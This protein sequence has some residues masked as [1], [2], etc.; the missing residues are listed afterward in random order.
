MP[1]PA[2]GGVEGAGERRFLGFSAFA[3]RSACFPGRRNLAV[4]AKPCAA[5]YQV[6]ERFLSHAGRAAWSA[7]IA[8]LVEHVIRNDGVGGS[9]P[10]CGT[11]FL[12]PARYDKGPPRLPASR[13]FEVDQRQGHR[14]PDQA[15]ASNRASVYRTP[16]A[17]GPCS[18]SNCAALPP[19]PGI[20]LSRSPQCR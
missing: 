5:R 9:S 13:T 15:P 16:F 6:R 1:A 18:V 19:S 2:A 17:A 10:S 20:P 11:S 4:L 7:A 8:Q 3:A 14:V 12:R